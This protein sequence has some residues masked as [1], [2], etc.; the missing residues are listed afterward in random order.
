[1]YVSVN[2]VGKVLNIQSR[3]Q[4]LRPGQEFKMYLIKS[5]QLLVS[6]GTLKYQKYVIMQNFRS[7]QIFQMYRNLLKTTEP[8]AQ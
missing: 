2:V 3:N 4:L 8:Q 5:T 6:I 1:M 7:F